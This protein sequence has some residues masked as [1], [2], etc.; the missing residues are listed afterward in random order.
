MRRASYCEDAMDGNHDHGPIGHYLGTRP[1]GA[2]ELRA[3]PKRPNL[4]QT[5]QLTDKTRREAEWKFATA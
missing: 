5:L 1:P 2:R 3:E 4:S